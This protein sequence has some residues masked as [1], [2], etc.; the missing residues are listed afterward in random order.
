MLNEAGA[1]EDEVWA[2][3]TRR[4]ASLNLWAVQ[5]WQVPLYLLSMFM[6]AF[7]RAA[8]GDLSM[9]LPAEGC[10]SAGFCWPSFLLASGLLA[11]LYALLGWLF[12]RWNIALFFMVLFAVNAPQN[13][14]ELPVFEVL[15][16]LPGAL[17]FLTRSAVFTV[18]TTF[19][20]MGT[21]FYRQ[22]HQPS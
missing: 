17:G 22:R 14:R 12:Q 9:A 8:I 6:A 18:L 20:M 1:S 7:L 15:N 5:W 19:P 21:Y 3:D 2:Q 4:A 10:W 11:L 16:A 13:V